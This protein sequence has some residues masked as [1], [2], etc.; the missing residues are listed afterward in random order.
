MTAERYYFRVL[1]F[2]LPLVLML[3][4]LHGIDKTSVRHHWQQNMMT[5]T[6]QM[7]EQLT[8]SIEGVIADVF[9]IVEDDVQIDE[10]AQGEFK[11]LQSRFQ[12]LLTHKKNYLQLRYIDQSG[13]ER[14]RVNNRNGQVEV[15]AA[16]QLQDKHRRY[17]FQNTNTMPKGSIYVSRLDLNVEQGKI[18]RPIKPVIRFSSPVFSD[19]G[20]RLGIVIINYYLADILKQFDLPLAEEDEG[21]LFLVSAYGELLAGGSPEKRWGIMLEHGARFSIDRPQSW[22][23]INAHINKQQMTWEADSHIYAATVYQE[24][25]YINKLLDAAE[26]HDVRADDPW[27]VIVSE[28]TPSEMHE[29]V[30]QRLI[31]GS[32]LVTLLIVIW[33]LAMNHQRKLKLAKQ[34]ARA[35]ANKMT[36]IVEQ[37]SDFIFITDSSGKIEYVNPAFCDVTGYEKCNL[38]E[39]TPAILKSGHHAQEYYEQLWQTIQSGKP[40]RGMMINRRSDDSLYYEEKTITPLLNDEG[41]IE[42]FVSIGKDLTNSEI[43]QNAFRDP[44]TGLVNRDL[45]LDRLAYEM[46][47]SKRFGSQMALLYLDLDGF[48]QVNDTLGHHAGDELLVHFAEL[49]QSQLRKSD[50]VSRLGGDEFAILTTGFSTQLDVAQLANKLIESVADAAWLPR[51]CEDVFG[52]SIGIN[53]YS[54]QRSYLTPRQFMDQADQAMYK[55]KKAGKNRYAFAFDSPA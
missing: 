47:Q 50:T 30:Y 49:C 6:V 12:A 42:G 5:S 16:S 4:V 45:L 55:A 25:A 3:L 22:D 43:T 13:M 2:S 10:I 37:T 1:A 24:E 53:V 32:L 46:E 34:A 21:D 51:N 7:K 14:V 38:L 8:A 48:K 17:Y 15:V 33:G 19:A 41:D 9:A 18:E 11:G 26:E 39:E 31:W 36:R 44:L 27:F 23:Y 20:S 28:A 54:Q 40:F 29:A 35:H 52:V